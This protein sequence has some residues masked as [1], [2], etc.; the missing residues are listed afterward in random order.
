MTL[1]SP[2]GKED[3]ERHLSNKR[4]VLVTPMVP[5]ATSLLRGS[6]HLAQ[7]G[8]PPRDDPRGRKRTTVLQQRGGGHPR[9]TVGVHG[10][11]RARVQ[12]PAQTLHGDCPLPSS[13]CACVLR[14]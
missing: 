9:V 11:P 10:P 5:S 2:L 3:S 12:V 14:G 13:V 8:L 1:G 4:D 7:M 6:G